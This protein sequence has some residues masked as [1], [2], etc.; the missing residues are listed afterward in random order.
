MHSPACL[1]QNHVP[2]LYRLLQC[3]HQ[4]LLIHVGLSPA[5]RHPAGD[6]A[7][8][9]PFGVGS[10]SEYQI[11][12]LR[13]NPPDFIVLRLGAVTQLQHITQHGDV[14]SGPV[15]QHP[16][17]RRHG[18]RAGIV[19]VL[20]DGAAFGLENLLPSGQVPELA[21]AFGDQFGGDTQFQSHRH[22]RQCVADVVQAFQLHP[23]RHR[24]PSRFRPEAQG[25][26]LLVG[27][28]AL[29]IAALGQTE[30]G[31]PLGRLLIQIPQQRV[32]SVEQQHPPGVHALGDFQ[33]GLADALLG[34]QKLNVA[35]SDVHDHR[36]IRMGNP[37]QVGN[38][39]EMVHSHF[40]HRHLRIQRHFQNGH[41]HSDVVVVIGRGLGHPIG[42]GQHRRRHFL[43]G[44]LAHGAGDGHHLGAD[45]LQLLPGDVPQGLPGV[46]HI[47]GRVVPHLPAAQHR[48]SPLVHGRRDKVMPVPGALEHHKQLPRLNGPGIVS[49]TQESHVRILFFHSAAAPFGGLTQCNIRHV[50]SSIP[51]DGPR[52]LPVRPDDAS[53][54]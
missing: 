53:H 34:A 51:P 1:E 30:I 38:L 36:H 48:R 49:G 39:P 47:D 44:A 23:N 10:V 27:V 18:F 21:Q 15:A 28:K 50:I 35:G 13:G 19:A 43:G 8:N 2:G 9:H 5:L 7:V 42:A 45:A 32:V 40:Q 26:L 54:H 16:Q 4:G 14:P 46:F 41:G 52:P 17:R 11:R 31:N 20:D 6:G 3:R 33:L 25:L 22:R 29:D 24:Q 12:L 37:G